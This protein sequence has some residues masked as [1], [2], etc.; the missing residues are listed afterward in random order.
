MWSRLRRSIN[1]H[2]WLLGLWLLC[3]SDVQARQALFA[4]MYDAPPFIM[5][6]STVTSESDAEGIDWELLQEL[7][8]RSGIDIYPLRY[9]LGRAL[10]DV[11]SGKMDIITGLTLQ[12]ANQYQLGHLEQPYYQCH[13]R[14]Y[15][16]AALAPKIHRY[17]DLSGK[18]IGHVRGADYFHTFDQDRSLRK[19]AVNHLH[20]LP[21]K[22]LRQYNQLIIAQ[23]C[24]MDYLLAKLG[25]QQRIQPTRYDPGIPVSLYVGYSR[26]TLSASTVSR[27][28]QALRDMLAEG[29]LQQVADSYI[30]PLRSPVTPALP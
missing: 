9:P 24:Q 23:D 21:G 13:V 17:Q 1:G 4:A 20:Q 25:L 7:A 22:L 27:L 18:I 3:A 10:K 12:M 8:S 28:N 11:G 2:L 19:S 16:T 14:F 5:A 30:H 29:W 26:Q 15:A 6:R